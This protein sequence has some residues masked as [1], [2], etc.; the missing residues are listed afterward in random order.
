MP[1]M[2]IERM[3]ETIALL[4]RVHNKEGEFAKAKFDYS[5][6]GYGTVHTC[7]M[8]ACAGGYMTLHPPFVAEGLKPEAKGYLAPTFQNK[9]D[10]EALAL[11]LGIAVYKARRI[12]MDLKSDQSQVTALDVANSLQELL[13]AEQLPREP[14]TA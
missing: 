13:D 11:F 8:S 3:K 4:H 2:N 1:E 6:W 9:S 12:F 5:R 10:E 7:G 14:E